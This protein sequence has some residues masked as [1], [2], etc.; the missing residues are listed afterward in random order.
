MTKLDASPM[1]CECSHCGLPAPSVPMNETTFC[2]VGC[3]AVYFAIREGGFDTF[4][5]L[6]EVGGST[7]KAASASLMEKIGDADAVFSRFDHEEFLSDE[8]KLC[9][10]GSRIVELYLEGVHCAGCVWLTERLPFAMDGVKDARLNLSR[11]RLEVR[12]DPEVTRLSDVARWLSKYGYLAHGVKSGAIEGNT[13]AERQLLTRVGVT[14]AIA[15]NIMLLAVAEYSGMD[16]IN[17]PALATFARWI[18]LILGGVSL[19]YGGGVF[20]RRAYESLRGI[21]SSEGGFSWTRLSMDVPISLGILVGWLHSAWATVTQTGEVWFD[22]IATL[23]AA[24]LTARWLQMRGRRFAG[25]AAERLLALLPSTAR[26][27]LEDGSLEDVPAARLQVGDI[28]EVRAGEVV[29]ADGVVVSGNSKV[30]RAVVTGESR[31]ESVGPNELVEAGVTNLGAVLSVRVMAAGEETRVGQLMRWVEDGQRRRAP[32]VQWAD[33]IGGIFVLIVVLAALATGIFWAFRDPQH[34]VAHVVALLVITCPCALGMATPLALSVGVGRAARRGFFIKHDDV[35]QALA[36]PTHIIFDK[37]GTLTE[38]K[39][40]VAEYSI[41]DEALRT[42]AALEQFSNHPIALALQAHKAAIGKSSNVDDIEE[43]PGKG[44]QGLVDGIHVRVGR[45]RWVAEVDEGADLPALRAEESALVRRGMTPIAVAI[46]NEVQG[47]VGIGD[48]LREDAFAL[49]ETLR[50]RGI[51]PALLSG[52]HAELVENCARTLNIAPELVAGGVDPE[53]KRLFVEA[54]KAANPNAIVVMVGDGVNDATALQAADVGIAVDGGAQAALVAADIFV[55]REG[56]GP[57][58][59]LLDG[60]S[61]VM[62]TVRRN[63]AGSA[64]YNAGGVTL[65][66]MG[67]VSPL[68]GAIA[69]PISSLFVVGSSLL[70]RSF[71]GGEHRGTEN[72]D[73]PTLPSSTLAYTA[74]TVGS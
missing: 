9:D 6:R 53:Q 52:D 62:R 25:E 24:I 11:A 38:G 7:A 8:T 61:D 31:P 65:A 47:L 54:L 30:H 14:W 49:V 64:L 28:V 63:L 23:T 2:C 36:H 10:D 70:Q 66:A 34:A 68:L 42:A 18:S 3:E 39:M 74:S 41:G 12:W 1:R 46:G 60:A 21:F 40:S 15:G 13:S 29:P 43:V 33:Q 32:V 16:L 19:V 35:M 57:I 26:R 4:Y 27:V 72:Q 44:I 50:A 48:R 56:V 17:D 37:T 69:M 51:Q 5:K 59:E 71:K 55:T 67:L 45:L 20:F 22:S 73:S 58:L